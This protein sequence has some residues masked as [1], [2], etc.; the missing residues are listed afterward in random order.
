MNS[1]RQPLQSRFLAF[2]TQ[3]NN[4]GAMKSSSVVDNSA[5]ILQHNHPHTEGRGRAALPLISLLRIVTVSCRDRKQ[6]MHVVLHRSLTEL[7]GDTLHETNRA[8]IY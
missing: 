7:L 2:N 8:F 3:D 1:G 4:F 5:G 6:I